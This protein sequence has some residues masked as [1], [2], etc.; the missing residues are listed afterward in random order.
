MSMLAIIETAHNNT[1]LQEKFLKKPYRVHGV[2]YLIFI[3]QGFFYATPR[4][5]AQGL[6]NIFTLPDILMTDYIVIGGLGAAL[7]N[8]GLAGLLAL[9]PLVISKHEATGLTMGTLGVVIGMAFFGKNPLN[10]LPII[11]GGYLYSKYTGIPYKNCVLPSILA[12]CLAPAVT[13]LSFIDHIPLELG[14][15]FGVI[16]GLF[17][18]FIMAPLSAAMRKAHEGYNIY[19]VGFTAGLLGLVLFALFRHLSVDFHLLYFWSSGHNTE[20]AIFLVIMSVYLILCGVLYKGENLS[21]LGFMCIE[22]DDNDFYSKYREKTYISMGILGLA[23]FALMTVIRGDYSGPVLGGIV[24]VIG[25]GAFGKSLNNAAT[26]AAGAILAAMT[27]MALTGTPFNHRRF[28]LAIFFSTC[29][30]PMA[31]RFGVKWGLVAGF[32]HLALATNV[33]IFHGGMNLYNN[34]FAGGLTAM[35]LVPIIKFFEEQKAK[36]SEPQ[37][38][39]SD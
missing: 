26:I 8:I 21:I 11:L 9:A 12:T 20:L 25:F 23:C 37:G 4:E 17:I 2:M 16:I 38:A 27:S 31:K 36:K 33:G 7:V 39:S 6:W 1:W 24:S 34:G 13:Q 3:L 22:A 5:L 18:G 15:T 10:M 28:L 30:S 19:N 14:I 32:V 29:L 35:V